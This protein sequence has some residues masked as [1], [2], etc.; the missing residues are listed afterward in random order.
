MAAAADPSLVNSNYVLPPDYKIMTETAEVFTKAL[1]LGMEPERNDFADDAPVEILPFEEALAYMR[2]RVTVDK[3]TYY[4]LNDKMRYRAFTVGRLADG[5]AVKKVRGM[6]SDALEEGSGLQKFLQMTEGQLADAV[7]MGRGVG[8]YYETVYRTNTS[9]AYNVG[10]AIAFEETPP[11]ALELIGIDDMRQTETCH[12]LTVPPFRRPYDDPVWESLWPP[13]H[14]NCRTTVRAIYDEAEIE[15]AGGPDKFYSKGTPDYEPDKGFGAYPVDKTD[16]WWDL[17]DS[18]RERAKE[19]GLEAEFLEAKDALIGSDPL[20]DNNPQRLAEIKAAEDYARNVLGVTYADY[21]G[22]DPVVANEWNKHLERTLK[23][24]PELKD[25]LK[26]TGSARVQFELA[27][28]T[29][30]TNKLAEVKK[31]FPMLP[32]EIN[33]RIAEKMTADYMKDKEIPNNLIALNFSPNPSRL[34]QLSGI[35]INSLYGADMQILKKQLADDV[36]SGFHPV[37]TATVKA[38]YDHEVGHVLDRMLGL[39]SDPEMIALYNSYTKE[40]I[41][42]EL[43]EYGSRKIGDFIA[44]GWTEYQNNPDKRPLSK[45]ISDIIMNR[46]TLW[47]GKNL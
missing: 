35:S 18:M 34:H 29:Y 39:S 1:L 28:S 30:Y 32:E 14:F 10:R 33:M 17:T 7:G 22:I 44:E 21:T 36:D 47:K 9:T 4:A 13:F 41:T 46:Y 6:L 19:Y 24:H 11:I 40:A 20:P 38:A 23:E 31:R 45:K 3:E 16:K 37:G 25:K 8:W 2:K 43:S 5:D 42:A 15:D 27:R 26:F 12:A